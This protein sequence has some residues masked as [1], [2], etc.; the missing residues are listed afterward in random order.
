[1]A[2]RELNRL[3]GRSFMKIRLPLLLWLSPAAASFTAAQSIT[4]PGYPAA[5]RF[6]RVVLFSFDDWAFPFRN[7]LQCHLFS[8]NNPQLVLQPGGAG[9][10]AEEL[11]YYG[12]ILRIGGEL[13]LWY[14]GNYGPPLPLAGGERVNC[15]LCYATSRD[16]V[17][18]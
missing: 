4:L 10:P 1:M 7:H 15:C 9:A 2:R 18:W 3:N 12:T 16:G 6:D 17:H 5:G 14:T 11:L 8:G 13:H